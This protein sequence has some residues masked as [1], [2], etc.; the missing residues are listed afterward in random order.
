MD[1][2]FLRHAANHTGRDY[3]VGDIHGQYGLLQ[4]ALK[5]VEFN[6]HQDR[7]FSVG[8]VIDR[9]KDSHTCLSL[10]FEPWFY[11]VLGN[12]ERMALDALRNVGGPAWDHWIDNG[13]AWVLGEDLR[14]VATLLAD[15]LRHVPLAREVCARDG[16]RL[17]LVHAEPPRDWLFA[18]AEP[19]RHLE[20]LTWARTRFKQ[21]D[22]SEVGHIDAVAVGHTPVDEP[23]WLGNVCYLDTGAF[24]EDGY[25]T[26]VEL[27]ELLD[28]NPLAVQAGEVWA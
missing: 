7:L 21:R 9:G 26:V 11:P 24:L 3:V 27:H 12:H 14:E 2:L 13:G 4:E 16:R 18:E 19:H 15:A 25:L 20:Q 10:L 1:E 8:D 5:A 6:R 23:L 28:A 22:P 17:G